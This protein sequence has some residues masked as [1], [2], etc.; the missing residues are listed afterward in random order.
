[1]LFRSN[2]VHPIETALHLVPEEGVEIRDGHTVAVNLPVWL[3]IE[4]AHLITRHRWV[5]L[6]YSSSIFDEPVRP[7]LRFTSATGQALVQ[8]MNGPMLGSADWIGRV[9]ERT[10][11]VA[12]SPCRRLG[13]FRFRVDDLEPVSRLA[14]VRRGMA[15]DP[16]WVPWAARSRLINSR[17]EAWQA[18]KFAAA[19]TPIHAYAQWHAQF[20]R[21]LELECL[22]CPRADWKQTPTFRLLV[23]MDS[24]DTK[25]LEATI[26][27][28]LAQ[29]YPRWSLH[30]AT[31]GTASSGT[32]ATLCASTP[33][34]SRIS[35]LGSSR[36]WRG[37][38][39]SLSPHDRIA[40][41]EAGDVLPDYALA[42]LG[43]ELARQ[44]RLAVI[45]SDEDALASD[46]AL[47]APM[48][49]PDWS[50]VFYHS[51]H[52]VGRLTFVRRDRVDPYGLAGLQRLLSD[53]QGLLDQILGSVTRQE[54]GHIRRILYHRAPPQAR[55][56][57]AA[58]RQ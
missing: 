10:V 55:N 5:R 37:F 14:L 35:E 44:P 48:L 19:A 15:R 52:Y 31:D 6:R 58:P 51:T 16:F 47:H 42:V 53:E 24:A 34:D 40:V 36:D 4:P 49:K 26:R 13:H 9:P 12:I 46:G 54:V 11:A 30:L 20:S 32:L 21:P 33:G 25:P 41:I 18:L 29:I 2:A 39:A 23:R 27:S 45:Y 56:E 1:M 3:R 22:D 28:L 17:Q 8:A 7:L 43:E 50:P 57:P 38:S